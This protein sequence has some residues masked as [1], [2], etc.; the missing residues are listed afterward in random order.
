M[1][2]FGDGSDKGDGFFDA[3]YLEDDWAVCV[4]GE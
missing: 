3:S 2:S 4:S 1:V